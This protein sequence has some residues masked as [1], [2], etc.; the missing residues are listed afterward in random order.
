MELQVHCNAHVGVMHVWR[1]TTLQGAGR[2]GQ[3]SRVQCLP[4]LR[5]AAGA[6]CRACLAQRLARGA[7]R[8]RATPSLLCRRWRKPCGRTLWCMRLGCR[9]WRWEKSSKV[10]VKG[11]Q[12]AARRQARLAG[13]RLCSGSTL[14]ARLPACS[15]C[16]V[17]PLLGGMPP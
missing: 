3:A 12:L 13:R 10:R 11:G 14:P 7:A 5:G 16:A 9:W 17:L 15:Y 4:E 2:C 6:L 1:C 8:P